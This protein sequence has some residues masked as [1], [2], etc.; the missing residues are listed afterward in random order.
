MNINDCKLLFILY[1]EER[2]DAFRSMTASELSEISELG[3]T[4]VRKTMNKFVDEGFA[5]RGY[6]KSQAGTFY[7]TE[8]GIKCLQN[9]MPKEALNNVKVSAK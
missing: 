3:G 9:I 2:V 6:K 7:I 4:K 1:E 8:K 5:E